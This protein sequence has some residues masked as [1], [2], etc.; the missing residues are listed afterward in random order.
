[1]PRF[2]RNRSPIEERQPSRI[3]ASPVRSRSP[4]VQRQ[5]AARRV[6]KK[7]DCLLCRKDHP[8]RKCGKFL[9][10]TVADRLQVVRRHNY[11]QNCLAHSHRIGNCRSH[12]RCN[13]CNIRHHS[14]LHVP[15]IVRANERSTHAGATTVT[16][17]VIIRMSL[18]NEWC[19]VRGL[20]NPGMATSSIAHFLVE[21]FHMPFERFNEEKW[22]EFTFR[23]RFDG[24]GGTFTVR[25]LV[26]K[27]LPKTPPRKRLDRSVLEAYHNLR[28]ADPDFFEANS[29]NFV[30]GADVYPRILRSGLQ[31]STGG[32]PLAQDTA[33]GWVII[34][35][36]PM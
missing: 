14:L 5:P 12:H 30:L 6:I 19:R 16:P 1:M 25:A 21:R 10:L 33:L 3:A 35:M 9:N 2:V 27:S 32:S 13:E 4:I 24:E 31:P 26:T 18:K 29:I 17:T 23:T 11:C 28:L 20:L 22:C 34:G 8:L 36:F 7:P 15:A